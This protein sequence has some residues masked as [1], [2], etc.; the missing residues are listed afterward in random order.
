MKKPSI[1]KFEREQRGWSQAR[2]SEELNVSTRTIVRWE[3]GLAT[4]YPYYREQLCILFGKNARELG[5]LSEIRDDEKQETVPSP[6]SVLS[7]P[8]TFLFDPVI[9]EAL[10]NTNS[11]L[12]RDTLLAQIKQRLLESNSLALTAINGLPGIG[13]TALAMALV[14]DRLVQAQYC[15]GILWAGLGPHPNVLSLLTRW[16]S[17]LGIRASDVGNANSQE[18]WW[19]ALHAT[20][21]LRRMLLVIDDAWSPEDALALKVGGSNCA[22]IVT[23]RSPQV[24]FA[25]AQQETV[26]VPELEEADG[27]ALLARFVPQ[28]IERDEDAA[29]ELVRR[30]GRLPLAVKLMGYYLALQTLSGQPRRLRVAIAALQNAQRR[31]EVSIPSRWQEHPP[32]L[33]K[34]TPLSLQAVIA[35]SDQHLSRQAHNTLCALAVFPAKPNSFSEEAALAISQEPVEMLDELWDVG[36]LETSGPG[37]YMLHQTIVDYAHNQGEDVQAEQRLVYYTVQYLQMH[38]QDYESIELEANNLQAG[39]DLAIKLEMPHELFVAI[40]NFAAYMR[41]RSHHALA[42][43]YLQIAFKNATQQ[44]KP[45][46]SMLLLQLLAEFAAMREAYEQAEEYIQQGLDLAREH[47]QREILSALLTTRGNVVL[48]R[49]DY[50]HAQAHFKEGLQMARQIGAKKQICTLLYNLGRLACLQ[51][52]YAQAEI[53]LLEG[54]E[55]ARQQ[56]YQELMV[57]LLNYLG[58]AMGGL[59]N[60]SK[61]EQYTLESL[62]LARQLRS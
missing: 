38:E 41:V 4:P 13:K 44:K 24:A 30:V 58:K 19:H 45:Q 52:D 35:V 16:G 60:Y 1:L 36:L 10:G 49:G 20:I 29:R 2:V 26:V 21:G 34:G 9:P 8:A 33:P 23:T 28:F 54:I 15:D 14:T 40:I 18:A 61:A 50:V 25:F 51:T 62:L 43:H 22:H 11:L 46:E 57:S 12:G 7:A 55:L 5:L 37:R 27:L 3:Q 39:L 47:E 42:D 6:P 56:E 17:L 48:H 53:V 32:S 59:G 31:L